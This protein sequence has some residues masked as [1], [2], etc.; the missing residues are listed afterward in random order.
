MDDAFLVRVLHALA[1]LAEQPEPVRYREAARVAVPVDA[2]SDHVLHGE[3]RPA[4]RGEAAIDEPRDA[5]TFEHRE[6]AALLVEPANEVLICVGVTDQLEGDTLVERALVALGEEYGA[7]AS[8]TDPADN[9]EG[10]DAFGRRIVGFEKGRTR[11]QRCVQA[12]GRGV[13]EV[14]GIAVSVEQ[15]ADGGAQVGIVAAGAFDEGGTFVGR[16]VERRV[17]DRVNAPEAFGRRLLVAHRPSCTCARMFGMLRDSDQIDMSRL[18]S[19]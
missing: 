11:K 2:L 15:S 4:A 12:F 13:H 3:P 1:D 7:H 17:E 18:I 19:R 10:A 5:R 14:G 16:Q 9:A 6:D 8:M